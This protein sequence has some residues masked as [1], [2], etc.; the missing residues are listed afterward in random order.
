MNKISLFALSIVSIFLLCASTGVDFDTKTCSHTFKGATY[1]LSFLKGKTQTP[2]DARIKTY[3]Y[4]FDVC[5]S[6]DE[7]PNACDAQKAK[8]SGAVQI[9]KSRTECYTLNDDFSKAK[10]ALINESDPSIGVSLTYSGGQPCGNLE[11]KRELKINFICRDAPKYSEIKNDVV[12]EHE[13][14]PCF[15]ETSVSTGAGCPTECPVVNDQVCGGNGVCAWNSLRFTSQCF[16]NE[17]KTGVDCSLTVK[18]EGVSNTGVAF[19]FL[20]ILLSLV[21]MLLG[22][23]WYKMRR[24]EVDPDAYEALGDKFNTVA[25]LS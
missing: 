24:L 15:Y 20:C 13:E 18:K 2:E 23:M 21:L 17:G 12:V 7:I 4:Q 25:M 10:I 1:D 8:L 19:I 5:K 3:E 9:N 14:K 6:L 11:T 16:C 22:F